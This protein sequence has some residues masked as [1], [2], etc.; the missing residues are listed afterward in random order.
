M[1]PCFKKHERLVKSD[2][3]SV[4][5]YKILIRPEK[6][7]PVEGS[8]TFAASLNLKFAGWDFL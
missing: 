1:K 2:D 7:Q 5:A 3:P 4:N 8:A 6:Q